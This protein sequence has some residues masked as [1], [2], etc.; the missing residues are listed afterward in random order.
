MA[1]EA[2][3]TY[4]ENKMGK[5]ITEKDLEIEH[6]KT[7]TIKRTRGATGYELYRFMLPNGRKFDVLRIG[8]EW[9]ISG[10]KV[11]EVNY[12]KDEFLL[13]YNDT[14]RKKQ[15]QKIIDAYNAGFFRL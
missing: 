14:S 11:D 7:A 12:G 8:R 9:G 6:L 15:I 2:F 13:V 5:P 3:T 10:Y 4:R 1:A